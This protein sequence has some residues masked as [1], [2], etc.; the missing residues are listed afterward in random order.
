MVIVT[1]LPW[2]ISWMSP[3]PLQLLD[4]IQ[5]ISL[6][7]IELT[8]ALAVGLGCTSVQISTFNLSY[9]YY[10]LWK[11]TS[12]FVLISALPASWLL[13][14]S[15]YY[16]NNASSGQTKTVLRVTWV[17][18]SWSWELW[19][20]WLLWWGWGWHCQCSGWS[21]GGTLLSPLSGWSHCPWQGLHLGP[22]VTNTKPINV[23]FVNEGFCN[24]I[25]V[26]SNQ[27]IC[28]N[29]SLLWQWRSSH[30]HCPDH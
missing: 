25:S 12:E 27:H 22:V 26:I 8:Q 19:H 7:H 6:C 30:Y 24:F 4:G 3:H 5:Q 29:Y 2:L 23:Y 10:L 20:C 21:W 11:W 14:H 17:W 18:S 15:K 9:G 28:D 13:K 1:L 16:V